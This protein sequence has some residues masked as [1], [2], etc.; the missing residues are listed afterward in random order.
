MLLGFKKQ[1]AP[2]ILD[3]SKKFTIRNPRKV[4]PKI[5]ETLHM[6]TGL[7]TKHTE[8]ITSEHTLKGIQLVDILIRRETT[9]GGLPVVVK[10]DYYIKIKVDGRVLLELEQL[11]FIRMD[12]FGSRIGFADYWIAQLGEKREY[13]EQGREQ[14]I[15]TAY[16]VNVKDLIMYH[17]TDLKF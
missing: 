11:K 5:G 12:G 17:W 10:H 1:F 16:T 6:Y 13:F 7:R 4:E 15:M 9:V 8:K 3:G 2:K 14:P